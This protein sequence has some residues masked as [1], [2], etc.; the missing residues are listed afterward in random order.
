MTF[1]PHL[2]RYKILVVEDEWLVRID[3]VDALEA[4]GLTVS[5][6]EAGE[7][8]LEALESGAH[9]D[10]LVTDIRLAGEMTG[11]DVADHYRRLHPAGGVIYASANVA[12]AA[13][14][15]A[16]SEFFTKPVAVRS[17]VEQ[18]LLFCSAGGSD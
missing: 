1:P 4:A 6:A 2:S 14:A 15:V 13:R 11:W 7:E 10:V 5:E 18:C 17:L 8:A 16:G 3:L 9:F 12:L